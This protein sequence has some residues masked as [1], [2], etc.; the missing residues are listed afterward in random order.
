MHMLRIDQQGREQVR[1]KLTE[2]GENGPSMEVAM[3]TVRASQNQWVEKSE[4]QV[5]V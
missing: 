3:N 1:M 2:N 5:N 4:M